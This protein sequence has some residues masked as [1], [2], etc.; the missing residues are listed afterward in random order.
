MCVSKLDVRL[1][2]FHNQKSL[3]IQSKQYFAYD[4]KEIISLLSSISDDAFD[5]LVDVLSRCCDV[6]KSMGSYCV[7]GLSQKTRH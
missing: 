4:E 7:F 1:A 5:C 3:F 6:P 2:E